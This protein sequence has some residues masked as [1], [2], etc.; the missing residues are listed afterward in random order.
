MQIKRH[1]GLV[2]KLDG[3]L[4]SSHGDATRSW[5]PVPEYPGMDNFFVMSNWNF[6]WCKLWLL[7]LTHPSVPPRTVWLCPLCDHTEARLWI[8]TSA[9]SGQTNPELPGSVCPPCRLLLDQ[10]APNSTLTPHLL[11]ERHRWQGVWC[12]DLLPALLF[13]GSTGCYGFDGIF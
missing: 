10:G 6:P 4:A 8:S 13:L 7:P 1:S 5:T 2:S 11:N 9:S 3:H 12:L